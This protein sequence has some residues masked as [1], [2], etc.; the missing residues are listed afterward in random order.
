MH[1]IFAPKV[2]TAIDVAKYDALVDHFEGA[3]RRSGLEYIIPVETVQ[4]IQHCEEI[5]AAS[6]G[7]A[8]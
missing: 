5:A 2:D 3:Q 7:S 8:R 4:G 6:L 1:G